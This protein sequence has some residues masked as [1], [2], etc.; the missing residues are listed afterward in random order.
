TDVPAYRFADLSESDYGVALLNDCK[1]GYHIKEQTL[2]LH[3]MRASVYPDETADQGDH[4]FT[5]SLLPHT[6]RLEHSDVFFEAE[7]LNQPVRVVSMPG[8]DLPLRIAAEGVVVEAVKL[9]EDSDD[10]LLRL[11]ESRGQRERI[12]L[13]P[14]RKNGVTFHACSLLEKAGQPLPISGDACEV[15]FAPF[16]IK[17]VMCR[18]QAQR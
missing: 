1:Y 2:D 17:T 15:E 14:A 10:L 12:K 6:G 7:A 8:C 13:A 4:E 5:Y 18:R 9:A 16:E 3:L 11:Y